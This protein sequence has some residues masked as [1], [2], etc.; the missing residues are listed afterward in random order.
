MSPR[1]HIG[2]IGDDEIEAARERG[3]EIAGNE[4]A[5]APR[6]RAARAL[7]ARDRERRRIAVG[8]DRDGVRQFGEQRKQDRAGAGAEIGDA[9]RARARRRR[10][11]CAASAASTTVS[12]SGRGTSTAGETASGRPQNSLTPMMRATGSPASRRATSASMPAI[13][14][15]SERPLAGAHQAGMI[16]PE[17]MADQEAGVE[18]GRVDAAPRSRRATSRRMSRCDAPRSA[19]RAASRTRGSVWRAPSCAA[20]SEAW[21]SVTSA[22]M[23]SSS[24][25]PSITWGSL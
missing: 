16:E 13:S 11:R 20:S 15:R 19:G 17:R 12:V 8:A 24:A 22:S 14:A 25:S 3:A 9:Q 4:C 18:I 5:R 7:R 10:G 21:C 6:R 2:R 23:I 1:A